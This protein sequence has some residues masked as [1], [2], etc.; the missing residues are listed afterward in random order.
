MGFFYFSRG[1]TRLADRV[2]AEVRDAVD[3]LI[4]Q[5]GRGHARPDLTS[6]PLLFYRVYQVYLIYDPVS[7]PLYI[8]RVY[9]TSQDAKTRLKLE[10]D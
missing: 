4:E 1:G 3:L 8:A 5:P 10:R 9:H 7:S 2:L 6:R